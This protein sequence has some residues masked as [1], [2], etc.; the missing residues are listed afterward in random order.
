MQQEAQ[1]MRVLPHQ[2]Q[3]AQQQLPVMLTQQ[4]QPTVIDWANIFDEQEDG[5]CDRFSSVIFVLFGYFIICYWV[6][7]RN[8]YR[9]NH[10][11]DLPYILLLIV[12]HIGHIF[13]L[14]WL[15]NKQGVS[16]LLILAAFGP[17]ILFI[18][19]CK[20]VENSKKTNA[21]RLQQMLYQMQ[22]ANQPIL[23]QPQ[24]STPTGMHNQLL[25]AQSQNNGMISVPASSLTN[26]QVASLIDPSMKG[27]E[28]LPYG[29]TMGGGYFSNGLGAF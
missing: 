8:M 23:T 1:Y 16:A 27:H 15:F 18:I 12:L 14:K 3:F 5:V 25:K 4:Q 19:F 11:P 20:Y 7:M 28:V 21:T 13:I 2:P 24:D 29:D 10:L 26:S 9:C 22:Q 6:I 17:M